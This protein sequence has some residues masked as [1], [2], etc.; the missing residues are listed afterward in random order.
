[1]VYVIASKRQKQ[2]AVGLEAWQVVEHLTRKH[3][4][5]HPNTSTGKK[6]RKEW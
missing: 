2:T 5:L 6:R 1:M 4:T 3:R